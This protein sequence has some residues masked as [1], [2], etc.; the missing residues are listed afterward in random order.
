[1]KK[2]QKP[3]T[4]NRRKRKK[5]KITGKKIKPGENKEKKRRK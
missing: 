4:G 5:R 2:E 3:K 1:M